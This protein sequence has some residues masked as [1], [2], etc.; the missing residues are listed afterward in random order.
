[1]PTPL[2]FAIGV[3][4][5]VLGIAWMIWPGRMKRLQAKVLYLGRIDM[6]GDQTD[7]ETLIGRVTGAILAILGIVLV[8]GI[9]P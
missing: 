9:Y 2:N 1:M 6:D 7:T 5:V 8:L 4:A 3:L